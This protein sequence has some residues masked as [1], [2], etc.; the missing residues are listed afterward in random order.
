MSHIP[1]K[2]RRYNHKRWAKCKLRQ[3]SLIFL[4]FASLINYLDSRTMWAWQTMLAQRKTIW[5]ANI[6]ID[7]TRE[8]DL[9]RLITFSTLLGTFILINIILQSLRGNRILRIF[10]YNKN[11]IAIVCCTLIVYIRNTICVYRKIIISSQC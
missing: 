8:V 11:I 2:R 5:T 7:K 10:N 1:T 4:L 9:K 3:L 6:L